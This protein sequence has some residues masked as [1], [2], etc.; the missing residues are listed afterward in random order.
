MP[1]APDKLLDMATRRKHGDY[2]LGFGN[3][4]GNV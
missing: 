4:F 3:R 2:N 1:S